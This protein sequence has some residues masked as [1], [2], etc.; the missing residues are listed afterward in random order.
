MNSKTIIIGVI[1][2]VLFDL[3][4][5]RCSKKNVEKQKE[6][7]IETVSES[8]NLVIN[9]GIELFHAIWP[10]VSC[11]PAFFTGMESTFD[12]TTNQTSFGGW[13]TVPV[14][15]YQAGESKLCNGGESIALLY[16]I[17]L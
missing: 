5:F 14:S 16:G 8:S 6:T 7:T 4:M 9:D 1:L 15:N 2:L 3:F 10:D 17:A 12:Y 13:P 11:H